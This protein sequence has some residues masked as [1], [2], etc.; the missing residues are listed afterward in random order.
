MPFT[1][2]SVDDEIDMQDLLSQKFRKEIRNQELLFYH[3]SNGMEGIELLKQHPAIEMVLADINMPIMDGLSFLTEVTKLNKPLLKVVIISAYGDMKNIRLAMNRGAFDFINKPIDFNDLEATIAKTQERIAFL[4]SQQEE[5]NRLTLIENELIAAAQIQFSL[6]PRINGV[7]QHFNAVQIGSFMKPAKHVGGD[8]YDVFKIDNQTIGFVIADV[9]GKGIPASSFMLMSHTA[10]N[11][12]AAQALQANEVLRLANNYLVTDNKESMFTTIFFGTLNVQ[13]GRF[14]FSNGGHNA[15]FKINPKEIGLL[16]T[17]HNMAMGIMDELPYNLKQVDLV[18]G[19][20]IFMY[21]D[22]V[23]EAQ[24]IDDEE[25]GE[26]RMIEVFRK[27]LSQSP[28][29]LNQMVFEA[30][31]E[32]RGQ[33]MQFDDI[34][35]L[36]FQWNPS[37]ASV[38][39]D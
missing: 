25:F 2:L 11:I 23:S 8:F 27:A 37:A 18:A 4:K 29:E 3:A 28:A 32:F 15:P 10:I 35:M 1:I 33:A 39:P 14:S 9:S 19:D 31:E 30:L 7:F 13:T 17:T 26:S 38:V 12:F 34:T 6:L 21:T 20:T 24:N 22:G 36:S 5:L 16:E